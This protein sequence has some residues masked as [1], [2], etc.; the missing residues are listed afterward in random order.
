MDCRY[1]VL[2]LSKQISVLVQL[3]NNLMKDNKLYAVITCACNT[4]CPITH[5]SVA[6]K[7][8]RVYYVLLE[9]F[10]AVKFCAVVFWIMTVYSPVGR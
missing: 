4:L 8:V 6:N 3:I 2:S 7:Q 10:I 1:C 5:P 9:L